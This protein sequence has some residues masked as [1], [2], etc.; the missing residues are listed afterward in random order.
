MRK[1]TDSWPVHKLA[2]IH[3]TISFPE[4]QRESTVWNRRAKQRLIDSMLRQFDIACLYFY[5]EHSTAVECIDGRQRIAAIMSFLGANDADLED[6]GF[7]L[8]VSNEIYEDEK[9]R[10]AELDG[11][12]Y[13]QIDERART[14]N[15]LAKDFVNDFNSYQMTVVELS[16]SRDPAEFNLQFTRLNLG[17]ILNSGEKLNAMIGNMR[18]LCF[19]NNGLGEH[20]FFAEIR[21]PTRRFAREQ[22]AAQ[23]LAQAFSW[24]DK[25][26]FTSTRHFDL[27]K[28]FKQHR[29][30]VVDRDGRVGTVRATLDRLA[31]AFES[32]G[33]LRNRAITVSVVL[34]AIELELDAQRTQELAEFVEQFLCRLRWQAKKGFRIDPAYQY[35]MDFNK[36]VTQASVERSA[37]SARAVFLRDGFVHW[38]KAH[39]VIGDKE[40]RESEGSDPNDDCSAVGRAY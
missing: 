21:I 8:R 12:T 39:T 6:N 33:V 35:L 5:R 10:Y 9:F 32:P 24:L 17:M 3:T 4:Y 30:L 38:Q 40:Y 2:E 31:H 18:E 34:L 26:E 29:N 23:V 36:H 11:L 19:G 37:V 20:A 7:P 25:R 27:Q 15:D 22:V 13:D 1:D 14:G 16:D 28:F